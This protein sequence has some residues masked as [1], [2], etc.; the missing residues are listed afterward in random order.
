M[1][2]LVEFVSIL[3]TIARVLTVVAAIL[4]AASS[5]LDSLVPQG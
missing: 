2:R 3:R 5:A 1:G 4:T